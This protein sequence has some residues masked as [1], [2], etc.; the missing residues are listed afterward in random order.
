MPGPAD[1]GAGGGETDVADRLLD[2]RLG[3]FRRVDHRVSERRRHGALES[4]RRDL[5]EARF[6]TVGEGPAMRE[7]LDAP[8]EAAEEELAI[9]V[10]VGSP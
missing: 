2:G 3:W 5:G 10:Q 9:A 1:H 7:F 8:G 6:R 4:V